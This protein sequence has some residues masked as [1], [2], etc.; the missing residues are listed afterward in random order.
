MHFWE[1]IDK[2]NIPTVVCQEQQ[3]LIKMEM[4]IGM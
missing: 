3:P 4:F 1:E 2:L